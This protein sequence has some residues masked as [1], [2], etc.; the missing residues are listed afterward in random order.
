MQYSVKVMA[1]A[2]AM[3]VSSL[4]AYGAANGQSSQDEVRR[5]DLVILSDPIDPVSTMDSGVLKQRAMERMLETVAPMTGDQVYEIKKKQR[6]FERALHSRPVVKPIT[7]MIQVSTKPGT[8]PV[9]IRVS[10]GQVSALNIIDST[11]EPWPITN[12]MVGNSTDYMVTAIDNHQFGNIVSIAPT[13]ISGNTNLTIMLEGLATAIPVQVINSESQ[14]HPAPI[15]QID[16]D[17]PNAR[18]VTH[19]ADDGLDD[20]EMMRAIVI[21]VPPD[22]ARELKTNDHN[23]EAWVVGDHLYLRT[24]YTPVAPLARNYHYGPGG[25]AA[26]RM[27]YVPVVEMAASDGSN[28]RIMLSDKGA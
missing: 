21:G 9:A 5:D 8:P 3:C 19:I 12:I 4:G 16:R 1:A 24:S 27:S 10:Q 2:I 13:Q 28:R 7:E 22:S 18:V 15:L 17:G 14:Y 25:Y 26:Y 6:D 11:G 23:V 20:D